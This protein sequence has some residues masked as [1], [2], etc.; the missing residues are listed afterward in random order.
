MLPGS[1]D[2]A[3]E[4]ARETKPTRDPPT[5]DEQINRLRHAAEGMV[6][7]AQIRL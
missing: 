5:A 6:T 1:T 4:P 2:S 7:A 3:I